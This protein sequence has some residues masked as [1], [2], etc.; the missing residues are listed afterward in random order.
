M[1]PVFGVAGRMSSEPNYA[2]IAAAYVKGL[3]E[4]RVDPAAVIAWADD[5]LCN[6]PDTQDWMVEISTANADD[7]VGVVAQLNTVKGDVDEA[8]VAD[9]VAKQ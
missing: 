8:A 1:S 9:L 6:D 5:L 2:T 4:G 7:R 3:T